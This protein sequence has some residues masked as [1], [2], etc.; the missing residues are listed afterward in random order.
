MVDLNVTLGEQFLEVSIG[1]SVTQVPANCQQ[2]HLRRAP[3]P[4]ERRPGWLHG[5]DETQMLH[6]DSLVHRTYGHEPKMSGRDRAQ[7]NSAPCGRQSRPFVLNSAETQLYHRVNVESV[8]SLPS[9]LYVTIRKPAVQ[10]TFCGWPN[11]ESV[12]NEELRWRQSDF[13]RFASL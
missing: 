13:P 3:E 9:E 8:V 10:S 4:G 11:A 1:Q 7:Y 6:P 5:S 2:Y 12:G